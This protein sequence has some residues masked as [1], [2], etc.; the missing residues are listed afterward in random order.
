MYLVVYGL[1]N[2]GLTD[3]LTQ[4]L[5]QC[6]EYGVWGAALGTGLITASP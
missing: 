1:P 3:Y 6:A 4:V 5:N 2:A